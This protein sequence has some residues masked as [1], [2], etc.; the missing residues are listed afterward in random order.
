MGSGV[1]GFSTPQVLS[2]RLDNDIGM[3]ETIPK[4]MLVLEQQ[5]DV[6]VILLYSKSLLSRF[7]LIE[8]MLP[9]VEGSK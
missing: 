9:L 8:K 5:F 1:F 2:I 3:I 6:H 4:K 7:V